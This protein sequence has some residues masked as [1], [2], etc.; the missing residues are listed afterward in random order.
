RIASEPGALGGFRL[1][2]DHDARVISDVL[3][4][5]RCA[6]IVLTRAPLDSYISWKIAAATGQWTL[7]D[8]KDRKAALATFD[9]P[10]F[11]AFLNRLQA[12]RLRLTRALQITGQVPFHI[13]YEDIGDLEVVNGLADWLGARGRLDEH[14]PKLKPQNPGTAADK[15]ANPDEMIEAL[16]GIDAFGL[17]RVPQMEPRRSPSV[18]TFVAAPEA[19][20][21]FLPIKGGP[22]ERI[23][24]WLASLDGAELGTLRRGFTR[25]S[26]RQWRNHAKDG[27]SFT[28]LAHPLDR[29]HR[30]FLRHILPAD[31]P[32]SFHEIRASLREVY[33]LPLPEG[34]PGP[35]WTQVDHRTAFLGF[36]RF[37]RANL[38][39]Q[40]SLRSDP[41]WSSQTSLL[42]GFAEVILPDM[43]LREADL[44]RGLETLAAQIA[45]MSPAL[46]AAEAGATPALADIYDEE[47][48]AAARDVHNVDFVGFGFRRW[49]RGRA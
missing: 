29:L 30:A 3:A 5:P 37:A 2:Q 23:E 33:G 17:T 47:I 45:R 15:V 31:G 25:K 46:P 41:A 38:A 8:A 20:A 34:D 36:L 18:P 35:D 44:A 32:Q 14:R 27:R 48:E 12:F 26:L 22:T 39:G 11:D 9:A 19:P 40:T 43:I 49:D 10:E 13:A 28:V 42:Q 24:A 16:S 6:K 21:L 1:F 7:T 4:T